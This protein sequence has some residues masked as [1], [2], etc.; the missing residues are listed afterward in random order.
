VLTGLLACAGPAEVPGPLR[1]EMAY[2]VTARLELLQFNTGQPQRVLRRQQISGL[3]SGETLLGIDYRIARGVLFALGSSGR[4]YTLD[5]ATGKLSAVGVAPAAVALPVGRVGFDFNPVADRIRVV[6]EQGENLRIHPDTG[7]PVDGD[8]AR[9]GVQPDPALQYAAGD[10]HGG[11]VPAIV[12]AAYT[13]N[14]Q[15]DRIT[16]NYA[17][18]RRTGSLVVQGSIEGVT[19]VVSPNTGQMRTVGLLGTGALEDASFDIADVSGAALAAL[20][21]DGRTR[22]YLVDLTSGRA[23]AIGTIGDGGPLLGFA[24][25]P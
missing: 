13:Y 1:K 22:L 20:R 21:L 18:D 2:A 16:T 24:I 4:L 17:I 23:Q 8:P 25:E 5:P 12:A 3:G 15:N 6:G 10:V 11:Q 7:A 14:K 9:D 19:P